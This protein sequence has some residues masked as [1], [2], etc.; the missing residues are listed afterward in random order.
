MTGTNDF[1][2]VDA[3]TPDRFLCD[4][5]DRAT[6]PDELLADLPKRELDELVKSGPLRPFAPERKTFVVAEL[7]GK[8]AVASTAAAALGQ[9]VAKTY[10]LKQRLSRIEATSLEHA[11]D[12][13]AQHHASMPWQ[14]VKITRDLE[15]VEIG[16]HHG[17]LCDWEKRRLESQAIA[18][19]VRGLANLDDELEEIR[20][21]RVAT[22]RRA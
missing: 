11:Q 13:V 19:R 16:W 9:L 2:A 21:E 3:G 5:C 20:R 1:T 10:A 15:P 8:R 12:L 14:E 6:Y 4:A 7:D 22:L 17:A 18:A